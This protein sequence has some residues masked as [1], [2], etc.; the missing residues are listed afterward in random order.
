[1]LV[2]V[3]SVFAAAVG[4]FNYTADPYLL[5]G[6]ADADNKRLG[7][8]DQFNHMRVTKPWYMREI[9]AT[10]VVA[11]SS[12]SARL[13]PEHPA[14]TGEQGYNLAAPGMTPQEIL[15]YLQHAHAITPLSKVMLGLDYEAFIRTQPVTKQGFEEARLAHSAADLN[16]LESKLQYASDVL[17][18]LFSITGLT[19]SIAATTG[20]SPPPR[21][22]FKDG[23]WETATTSLTG[24]GGYVYI[25]K[26]VIVAHESVELNPQ[27][28]LAVL[29]EILRFCYRNKI[30]TRLFFTPTH[31]FFVDLW[32]RLGYKSMWLDF[33]RQ[34]VALNRRVAE[35]SSA[36]AFPL[37]G[38][39][40]ADGI[41]N[42]P[43]YRKKNA[44][45][46]WYDDGVHTRARLGEK[47]MNDVWSEEAELGLRLTPGNIE[48]YLSEVLALMADFN[49]KNGPMVSAIHRDIGLD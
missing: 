33:H 25:G 23:T 27:R 16:S 30:D 34:I 6:F 7:R 8:I 41:V 39:S 22:Y 15:R 17:D 31:V 35:E 10:A 21:L 38:F 47:M 24:R 18:S 9:K 44:H 19:R 32:Q 29:E 1:M 26:T 43:I 46:A 45:Q 36:T 4:W 42:E 3:A 37:W 14:W 49:T 12:R 2:L 13:H 20:V 40:H 28:N 5:F 11:G 48:A